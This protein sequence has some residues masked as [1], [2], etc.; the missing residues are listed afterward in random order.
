[1]IFM[2]NIMIYTSMIDKYRQKN[3]HS[4][5]TEIALTDYN[6]PVHLYLRRNSS[7]SFYSFCW[8]SLRLMRIEAA[9][10]VS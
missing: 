3:A 8:L 2:K 9:C 6:S 7:S 10:T 4:G 1:M 5:N